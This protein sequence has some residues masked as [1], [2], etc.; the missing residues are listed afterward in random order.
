[1]R[2][3]GGDIEDLLKDRADQYLL[4]PSDVVWNNI[5]KEL[6]PS[7]TWIYVSVL[8]LLLFSAGITM[9]IKKEKSSLVKERAGQIAYRL[10]KSVE[11]TQSFPMASSSASQ[12]E[13]DVITK[14]SPIL[15]K[16][17]L[18]SVELQRNTKMH[19]EGLPVPKTIQAPNLKNRF[20]RMPEKAQQAY[21]EDKKNLIASALESVMEQ[22]K[23]IRSNASWQLYGGLN[24]GYRFLS[25]EATRTNYQY[26]VFSL[27]TNAQFPRNV[28]DVVNHRPGI[29]FEIGSSMYYP[30]TKKL[31]LKAGL[32]ANYNHYQIDAYSS[33]PEV[34]NYGMNNLRAGSIPIS[35]VSFYSN[36][37]GYKKAT[38]RNEHYMLSM[39][40]GIDYVVA[41]NKKVNLSLASTIQPTYVFANYSYLISTNLKNY[42]KEPTLNRRWN[43]NSGVE[44][45]LNIQQGA[46]KWSIA[47]QF[48]Y[49][50]ISSFKDKYPIR[51]NLTDMGIKVGLIRTLQ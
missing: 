8:A 28:K 20:I 32:Q 26:A 37:D 48:R 19:G 41:G 44:A 35:T 13:Q 7:R 24:M 33:V 2:P 9:V 49:Q 10:S 31:S 46:F 5:Q 18:A 4:Y 14:R 25:G 38:L 47:P 39:P 50:L 29:G 21:K 42:A 15:E 30:I 45:S 40:I 3:T 36:T 27:S 16:S 12:H 6:H 23:K 43:I 22:A 11:G 1:M 17:G 34:A 51:E